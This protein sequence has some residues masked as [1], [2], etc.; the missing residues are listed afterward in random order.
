MTVTVRL[1][2]IVRERAGVEAVQLQLPEAATVQ[3]ASRMLGEKYPS[4]R[5]FLPRV[6][7]AV[8]QEYVAADALLRDGDELAVIPPVSGGC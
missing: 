6:A 5:D 2:A 3:A 4:L 7:F 8:N 1:F